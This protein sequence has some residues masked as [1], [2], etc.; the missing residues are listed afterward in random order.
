MAEVVSVR[1]CVVN[2]PPRL[3]VSDSSLC[4]RNS[5]RFIYLS[6]L[7]HILSLESLHISIVQSGQLPSTPSLIGL[8]ACE[9]CLPW[10]LQLKSR[11]L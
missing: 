2:C 8:V 9:R 3:R 7:N 4:G 5:W 10:G 6:Y 11:R 1:V